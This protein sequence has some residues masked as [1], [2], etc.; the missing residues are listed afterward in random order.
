MLK[1]EDIGKKVEIVGVIKEKK[2]PYLRNIS[3]KF[4]CPSCGCV[5]SVLQMEDKFREP[6]R[7]SCGRRGGFK[8]IS[9][10]VQEFQDLI[11]KEK[12]SGFEF[13]VYL[14]EE[15]LIKKAKEF[16]K[17]SEVKVTGELGDEFK[18][19]SNKGDFIIKAENIE[20]KP[21][22]KIEFPK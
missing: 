1:K 7:C 15:K 13:K 22:K 10:E 3:V 21:S 4:E 17:D 8:I 12:D 2:N 14:G 9:K 5:M 18:K 20:S 19:G 16:K 6:T 11:L